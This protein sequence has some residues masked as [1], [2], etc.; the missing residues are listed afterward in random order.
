MRKKMAKATL[1]VVYKQGTVTITE[2]TSEHTIFG[3]FVGD[4]QAAAMVVVRMCA[5]ALRVFQPDLDKMGDALGPALRA[6]QLLDAGIKPPPHKSNV[7]DE[8]KET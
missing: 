1:T 7:A 6:V 4:R 5:A 2:D 8:R 3:T